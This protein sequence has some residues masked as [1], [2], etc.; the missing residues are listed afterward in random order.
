MRLAVLGVLLWLASSGGVPAAA[1]EP[2]GGRAVR[3]QTP[4]TTG[5]V[6]NVAPGSASGPCPAERSM[7]GNVQV[8]CLAED[9]PLVRNRQL[10]QSEPS[11]AA[12]DNKVVV[13]FNDFFNISVANGGQI[14]DSVSRDGG[15]SFIDMGILPGTPKARPYSDP[16]V[17]SD[18]EGNIWL[19]N[20]AIDASTPPA[21][22]SEI[23]LYK[24]APGSDRFE[25]VSIPVVEGPYPDNLA[26]KGWLTIGRDR[27]GRRHF[28]ITYMDYK[29]LPTNPG[30][31][32]SGSP[33]LHRCYNLAPYPAD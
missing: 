10:D 22:I 14:S 23:A 25:L 4:P 9:A 18:D 16:R 29:Y 26:D 3:H 7:T 1:A 11:V 21:I 5:P 8:N 6:G 28:Y 12:V 13:A 32:T 33:R 20:V 15:Q 17:A 31:G 27:S 30:V 2:V 24:M 19:E